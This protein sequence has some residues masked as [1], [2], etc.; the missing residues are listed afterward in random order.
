MYNS[1]QENMTM[2]HRTERALTPDKWKKEG[3]I[4]R[5]Y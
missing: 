1:R 4:W 5:E 3:A 2:E